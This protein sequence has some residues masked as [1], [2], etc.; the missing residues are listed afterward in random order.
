M[1][2]KIKEIRV[3]AN[4]NLIVIPDHGIFKF[5]ENT[6]KNPMTCRECDLNN[7]GICGIIPC[8]TSCRADLKDGV[9]QLLFN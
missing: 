9:F 8:S 7:M 5:T 3:K 1:S 4:Q 6:E 2:I